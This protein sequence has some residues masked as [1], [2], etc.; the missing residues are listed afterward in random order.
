MIAKEKKQKPAF[1][2][3]QTEN[4]PEPNESKKNKPPFLMNY[5][6]LCTAFGGARRWFGGGVEGG[7]GMRRTSRGFHCIR[8]QTGNQAME[9]WPW[10]WGGEG[11]LYSTPT[12]T[13][14]RLRSAAAQAVSRAGCM[15]TCLRTSLPY[16]V[17]STPFWLARAL[18]LIRKS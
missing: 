9:N 17:G 2:Q 15:V 6:Y 7:I 11:P 14:C 4:S 8:L 10:R 13:P 16:P 3:F 5:D 12:P 18:F 1:K